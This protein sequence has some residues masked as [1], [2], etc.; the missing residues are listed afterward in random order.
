MR[1]RTLIAVLAAAAL[2]AVAVTAPLSISS[3]TSP[4]A[5]IAKKRCKSKQKKKAKV[6]DD[7]FSPTKLGIKKCGKVKWKWLPTNGNPHN[8]TLTKGPKKV[9]KKKFTSATGSIGIKFAPRFKK[10]GKYKFICTIHP[11]TMQM[12]V[13][14][15]KK[16]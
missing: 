12:T 10:P 15:K 1:Y 8:V 13:K 14:V 16:K 5:E 3:A 11:T 4:Q 2:V 7:F 6:G 9:K